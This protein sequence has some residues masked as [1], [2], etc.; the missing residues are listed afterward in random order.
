M[1]FWH[2]LYKYLEEE[3]PDY[4]SMV[5]SPRRIFSSD[6]SGFPLHVKT[7][8]VLARTGSKNVYHV[9]NNT[10]IQIS[11]MAGF[12]AFGEYVPPMILYPG[13]RFR[14]VGLEGI[15]EATFAY[16]SNGWMDSAAFVEYLKP[17]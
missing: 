6:E 4:E 9:V 15:P 10:K 12:N 5:K 1:V 11:V 7:G 2:N 13:E 14:D 16:T 3:V 17:W 8:K